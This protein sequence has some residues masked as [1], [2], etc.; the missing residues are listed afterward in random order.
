MV[1]HTLTIN[2]WD[3]WLELEP[4]LEG[5]GG[6]VLVRYGDNRCGP[7]A[8]I[9]ALSSEYENGPWNGKKTSLRLD[10]E[11]YSTRF[12]G[13]V[14]EEFHR[15]LGVARDAAHAGAAGA[16]NI[17]CDN[18]AGGAQTFDVEVHIHA[19]EVTQARARSA[20]TAHLKQELEVYLRRG[21][22]MVILTDDPEADHRDFWRHMWPGLAPLT[23][24]GLLL[25]RMVG[26]QEGRGISPDAA[27]PDCEIRLQP[28]LASSEQAHAIEDVA[29]ILM[30]RVPG[31]VFERAKGLAEGCVLTNYM[32]VGALHDRV[33][34]LVVK[35][36]LGAAS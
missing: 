18:E 5:R 7:S 21:R 26:D 25:V 12:L 33:A 20:W 31:L 16:M 19:D 29:R 4:Y 13:D 17:L 3:I 28:T 1:V 27:R 10:A 32:D 2:W 23:A 14:R 15:K 22:L 36:A 35:V 6:V 8:F 34:G 30:D 9:Q 11:V 24:R